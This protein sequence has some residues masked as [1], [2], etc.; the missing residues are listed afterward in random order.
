MRYNCSACQGDTPCCWENPATWDR[1]RNRAPSD[2]FREQYTPTPSDVLRRW[3]WRW[4]PL[5]ITV[6]NTSISLHW[7]ILARA[8]QGMEL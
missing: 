1:C 8:H 5:H 3:R 2:Y 7:Y 6:T 4:W